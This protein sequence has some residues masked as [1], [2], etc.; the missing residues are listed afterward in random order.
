M[1]Y[2]QKNQKEIDVLNVMAYAGY[3]ILPEKLQVAANGGVYRCFNFGNDYTHCYT[4][5]YYVGSITAYL[6]KFTLQGYI[7]NGNR[8]LEG[9]SKGYNGAYS[10]L[11]AAYS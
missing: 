5:W 6:G 1:T 9:E 10:V 4:S 8:F 2:T 7:D 11:K 3:W